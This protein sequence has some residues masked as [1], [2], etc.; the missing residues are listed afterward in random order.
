MGI[1]VSPVSVIPNTTS[2]D[3][4]WILFHKA[5]KKQNY[6]IAT[7]N[8]IWLKYWNKRGCSG[9]MCAANTAELRSYVESQGISIEGSIFSFVPD[10]MD[11][12]SDFTSKAFNLSM[13]AVIAIVVILISFLGLLAWNVGRNPQ[14]VID[15]GKA[16]AT[17]G[18]ARAIGGL[19]RTGGI[20]A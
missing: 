12:F 4:D 6:G 16:Y 8:S 2:S 9:L 7:V 3:A 19:A 14:M 1:K 13:Y 17:G 10:A 15:A 11:D 5:M 20:A 18:S